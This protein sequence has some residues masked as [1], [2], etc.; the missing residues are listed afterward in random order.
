ME[1]EQTAARALSRLPRR[2]Q[3]RIAARIDD[4]ATNPRPQGVTKL[5]GAEGWR[6]RLGD[7]R[8]VYTVDDALRVVTITRIGHRSQVYRRH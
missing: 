5:S 8:V 2:D 6:I 3:T 1:I 4:L 7:Y